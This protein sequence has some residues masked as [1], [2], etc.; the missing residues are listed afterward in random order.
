L[1][2]TSLEECI[3]GQEEEGVARGGAAV[4]VIVCRSFANCHGASEH[5]LGGEQRTNAEDR[6]ERPFCWWRHYP[7]LHCLR[8]TVGR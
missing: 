6:N 7:L 3:V 5:S 4:A 1:F 2:F 8:R